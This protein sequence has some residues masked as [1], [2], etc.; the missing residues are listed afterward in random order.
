[1]DGFT[2]FVPEPG[3][4]S[5]TDFQ[6]AFLL[7]GW[8]SGDWRLAAR[9]E[10]FNTNEIRSPTTIYLGEHGHAFAAA[11][12]WLPN[13]WM[14]IT[15]EWVQVTSTRRQRIRDGLEP[16]QVENQGTLSLKLYF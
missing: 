16:K 2:F 14:R 12:N 9:A 1:M 5:R 13:D 8:E 4:D 15:A 6:S 10:V 11:V 3:R 7:A